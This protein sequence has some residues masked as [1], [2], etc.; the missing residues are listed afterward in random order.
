M[1]T[2]TDGDLR[3]WMGLAAHVNAMQIHGLPDTFELAILN[4]DVLFNSPATL[5]GSRLNW[6]H[7]AGLTDDP[8]GI[9]GTQL[10][11]MTNLTSLEVSGELYLN[12]SGFVIVL[13]HFDIFKSEIAEDTAQGPIDLSLGNLL[14]IK[15]TQ[16]YFFAG[17][18]GVID[19]DG[20]TSESEF[21][22]DLENAGALGFYVAGGSLQLALLS[23]GTG[24]T[25]Q[26]WMGIAAG[27]DLMGFTGLDPAVF[28]FRLAGVQFL[29]NMPSADG[30]KIDWKALAAEDGDAYKLDGTALADLD[31]TVDF[32]F[33]GSF[34]LNISSFVFVSG[35]VALQ[36]RELYA[37]PIGSTES[38]KMSV[39]SIG[40]YNVQVFAGLGAEYDDNGTPEPE[41]D[42]VNTSTATGVSLG[43]EDLALVLMKPVVAEGATAS[44]KK[45]FSLKATGTADLLGID[46]ITL[47]GRL[48]LEVN[49]GK[50]SDPLSDGTTPAIDYAASAAAD[51]TGYGSPDGL[52]VITG[53]DVDDTELISF[54]E[55][56]LLRASGYVVISLS[57]F[58]HVSGQFA[59]EKSGDPITVT[60]V[61]PNNSTGTK[62]VNTMTIGASDVNAFIGIGGPYFVDSNDDGIIDSNDTPETDGAMGFV[63][64]DAE[65]AM[66]MLK[67]DRTHAGQETDISSYFAVKASG[68]VE[69]VGIEGVTIRADILGVEM[70]SGKTGTDGA[71]ATP[72][73]VDFV[74]T[75]AADT[76]PWYPDGGL[77]VQTGIDPD[78]EGELEA[79][80]ILLDFEKDVIRA[81]GD[82]TLIIDNFVF[83][84]LANFIHNA[85]ISVCLNIRCTGDSL[86]FGRIFFAKYFKSTIR[87]V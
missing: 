55:D 39:L 4:L 83:T 73:V 37:K 38:V 23:V 82:V 29:M 40:A 56:N 28:S 25:A 54:T 43:V 31:S 81:Y 34:F 33:I 10:G 48:T 77:T 53:P 87:R 46:G 68:A 76:H 30:S 20:Y 6:S 85:D 75:A 57:E 47:G 86:I 72:Q 24:A 60:T 59:F 2:E 41:D 79:P 78:G 5:D 7:L 44:T 74:T 19:T 3:S 71:V 80:S 14:V 51:P 11:T 58:V 70:N 35:T 18:D 8:F 15:L 36:K 45:Y 63:L 69:I 13:A 84:T 12:I 66:A 16:I 1:V 9:F 64:S 27:I 22:T 62:V 65:F 17:V 26:K 50:D 32:L 49:Q 61:N 21:V 67:A 42:F 52:E